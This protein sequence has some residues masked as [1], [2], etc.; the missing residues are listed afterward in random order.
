M[1]AVAVASVELFIAL[2]LVALM[3]GV[4]ETSLDG[5]P[6][7]VP[8]VADAGP[9]GWFDGRLDGFVDG[10]LVGVGEGVPW[11]PP[12]DGELVGTAVGVG[13]AACGTGLTPGALLAPLCHAKATY[14][15][16]GTLSDPAPSEE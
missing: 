4:V 16:S 13:A 14:P 11:P 7:E 2:G 15:P 3:S 12:D 6:P 10:F 5:L 9:D 8:A 1:G